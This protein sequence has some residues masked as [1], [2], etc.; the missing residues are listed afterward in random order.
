MAE[1]EVRRAHPD[2][3]AFGKLGLGHPYAIEPGSVA[4]SKIHHPPGGNG[5]IK[6]DC[7]VAAACEPVGQGDE[8]I[9]GPAKDVANG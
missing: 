3:A 6:L 8:A 1:D 4:A 7:R 9:L 5:R 2:Q